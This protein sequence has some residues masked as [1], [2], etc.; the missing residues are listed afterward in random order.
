MKL[1]SFFASSVQAALGLAREELGADAILVNSR[2]A[3]QEAK[4]LGEYEV[5]AA[6]SPTESRVSTATAERPRSATETQ[7][8]RPALAGGPDQRL[9]GEVAQLRRQMERMRKAVWLSGLNRAKATRLDGARGEVLPALLE[10][11]LEAALAHEVAACVEARMAGDPL[12]DAEAGAADGELAPAGRLKGAPRLREHLRAEL[13]RRFSVDPSVG[14]PG[15][16][17]RVAALVGPAGAGKTLTLAKLAVLCGL[18]RRRPVQLLSLDSYR[19]ASAEPLRT[20]AGILGVGFQ[21]L[22][23]G[24]ALEQALAG[25]KRKDLVLIDTPGFG[26][27]D[28]DAAAEVAALLS[29]HPQIEI[30]LVL[31]AT[32]KPADLTCAV[33]RFEIFRPPKLLFTRVDET[34]TFGPAF[35]EAAR[36]GT[37]ISFLA[38][39][40]QVPDDLEKAAKQRIIDLILEC[41]P[42]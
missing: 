18:E 5:V 42:E 27:R 29:A 39:G 26:P 16:C 20:Y 6:W 35:S 8:A 1:K 15:A 10:A 22:S 33:D 40:Q 28:M 25:Q 14:Q 21:T 36:T 7:R 13:E 2:R 11:D 3:P 17:P 38:T 9:C 4:H 37:P 30:H 12:L 34:S 23:T 24:L 31:P 32:M 41:R 19:I